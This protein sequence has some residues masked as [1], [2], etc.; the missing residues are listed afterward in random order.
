MI[1]SKILKLMMRKG[2]SKVAK[3]AAEELPSKAI[4]YEED[5]EKHMREMKKANPDL[6]EKPSAVKKIK[7]AYSGAV[8]TLKTENP[9]ARKKLKERLENLTRKDEREAEEFKQRAMQD[10]ERE[11]RRKKVRFAPPTEIIED[12]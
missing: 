9:I 7:E 3:E 1:I 12:K 8:H 2:P 4:K 10:M 5:L 11:E 6:G